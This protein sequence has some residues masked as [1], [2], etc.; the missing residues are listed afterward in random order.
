[1]LATDRVMAAAVVALVFGSAVCFGGAVW[2]FRPAVSRADVRA[3]RHQAHAALARRAGAALEE[4]AVPARAA[5]RLALG[6]C[7]LCRCR[8]RWRAGSR[9]LHTRFTRTGILPALARADLPSVRL[10]RAGRGSLAGDARPGRDLAL[11]GGGGRVPGD[12]LGRRHFADRL[13]RLYLVWGSVVAAFV[14]NAA[15]GLVQIVGQAEGCTAFSSRGRPRS[16]PPRRTTCSRRPARRSCAGWARRPPRRPTADSPAFERI[17]LVPDRPFL[18]GTM[19]GGAGAFL[20]LGSL[21]LP[22]ALAI[23]LHVLSPRGSRESLSYRLKHTGQGGLAVSA[24]GHARR[25]HV[26]GR[27]DGRAVVLLAICP[28]DGGRRVCPARPARAGLSLGLLSL[29]LASLGLGATSR[30]RLAGLSSAA[31][32]RSRPISWRIRPARSGPRACRS[33]ATFPLVGTGLGS[34]GTIY[35][36]VKTHDASSTTAM[37]SLLQCG[38]ES[39]AV[40]LGHPRGGRALVSMPLAGLSQASRPGRPDAR[41]RLDRSGPGL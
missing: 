1:M 12:L 33:C 3:C 28:G 27:P 38:V 8:R 13:G 32:L 23:V 37:S 2:W 11:A 34:F 14:L 17:A 36:Y 31:S 4:P 6:S 19:M 26:P 5:W 35:P 9:R 21:A 39:G 29:L 41:L 10:E 15:F 24:R 30:C 25:E 7:S 22:L 16:G 40:G 20:A 18:F